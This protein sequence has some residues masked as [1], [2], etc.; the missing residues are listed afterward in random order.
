VL[1]DGRVFC[2]IAQVEPELKARTVT[3]N[4]VSKAYAM[5]GWRIGYAGAPA[6]LIKAIT[7][8]QS[9]STSNPSSIGQAAALEA[10]TGPQHFT[11]DRKAI[12]Q[13]RR[14]QV[15]SMLNAIP[16]ISCHVPEGAF[17]VFP[18]CQG[19]MGKKT[20]EGKLLQTDE[21]FVMYLLDS[22]KLAAVHGSAYGSTPFFRF[23]FATSLDILSEGCRR[24]ARACEKLV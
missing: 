6:E 17:Y 13:Q 23:S 11:A 20:P 14:D 16:G 18:S 10:L 2:N 7:K 24:L 19:V 22:E 15:V 8:L 12:F 4:G 5:T 9:Q 3:I 21:D 1:F